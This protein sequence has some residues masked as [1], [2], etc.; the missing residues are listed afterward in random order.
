MIIPQTIKNASNSPSPIDGVFMSDKSKASALKLGIDLSDLSPA[1]SSLDDLPTPHYTAYNELEEALTKDPNS[2]ERETISDLAGDDFNS[3]EFPED[4]GL[5]GS[6]IPQD[7]PIGAIPKTIKDHIISVSKNSS[8][9]HELAGTF[10][11]G[12]LCVALHGRYSVKRPTG[13]PEPCIGYFAPVADVGERKSSTLGHFCAPIYEYQGSYND[14]H[15]E[16]IEESRST[17]RSLQKEKE[18]AETKLKNAE[19]GST[20]K[21]RVRDELRNVLKRIKNHKEL[22]YLDFI[23]D[24][25]TPEKLDHLILEQGGTFALV[26]TEGGGIIENIGRYGKGQSKAGLNTILKAFTGDTITVHRMGDSSRSFRVERA[27]LTIIAACQPEVLASILTDKT[28]AGRGLLARFLYVVCPS[29]AGSRPSDTEVPPL[30]EKAAE[31]YKSLMLRI[32]SDEETG[33]TEVSEEALEVYNSFHS[34]VEPQLKKYAG[35]MAEMKG[36]GARCT[37][38]LFRIAG[39]LHIVNAY[40]R[41]ESPLASQISREEMEASVQLMFFFISHAKAAFSVKAVSDEDKNATYLLK[42]MVYLSC[43]DEPIK[44]KAL[45]DATHGKRNFNLDD[46]LDY[47]L[48]RRCIRSEIEGAGQSKKR[49]FYIHPK[50]REITQKS[51][52]ITKTR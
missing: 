42:K 28:L 26:T 50:A 22:H 38:Y 2:L 52:L 36:W 44:K 16:E 14:A 35:E 27:L 48:K 51:N 39:L 15:M 12:S 18:D 30:D 11:L 24:D 3:E 7:F 31:A 4:C 32:L 47:L 46:S 34:K 10:A 13:Y 8:A 29:L 49:I 1:P 45:I 37:G 21:D 17:A 25:C 43:D 20:E 33:D 19:P 40:E 9:P 5:P 6:V 23:G 41:H